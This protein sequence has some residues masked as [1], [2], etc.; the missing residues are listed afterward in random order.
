MTYENIVNLINPTDQQALYP[1][2]TP[3]EIDELGLYEDV[4]LPPSVEKNPEVYYNQPENNNAFKNEL[5]TRFDPPP[6]R[7]TR[8]SQAFQIPKPILSHFP[9]YEDVKNRKER[10]RPPVAPKPVLNKDT[11]NKEYET[12]LPRLPQKQTSSYRRI[13]PETDS[14]QESDYANVRPINSVAPTVKKMQ[15]PVARAEYQALTPPSPKE[16]KYRSLSR[17]INCKKDV[18]DLSVEDV[19]VYLNALNL[20]KYESHFKEH[21]IDGAML[22]ELEADLLIHDIGMKRLEVARLMRFAKEGRLPM[23]DN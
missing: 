11:G 23:K 17:S 9:N 8:V 21:M 2:M 1:D 22:V 5:K 7:A 18:A 13:S 4:P 10:T 3:E 14:M 15:Q 16:S 20:S 6:Q 19:C 12:V